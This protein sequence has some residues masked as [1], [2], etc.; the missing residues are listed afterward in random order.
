[1]TVQEAFIDTYFY[2][3]NENTNQIEFDTKYV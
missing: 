3:S 2:D 1:M